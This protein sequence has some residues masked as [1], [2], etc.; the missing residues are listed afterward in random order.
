MHFG[1]VGEAAAGSKVEGS[2]SPL[3]WL[4][5]ADNGDLSRETHSRLLHQSGNTGFTD[6]EQPSPKGLS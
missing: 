2:L 1:D 5:R 6:M 4:K 3:Q